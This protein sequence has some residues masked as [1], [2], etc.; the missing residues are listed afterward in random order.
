MRA[1]DFSP[2]ERVFQTR[3]NAPVYKL[4][5]LALVYVFFCPLPTYIGSLFSPLRAPQG[6]S[7]MVE[8]CLTW[9]WEAEVIWPLWSKRSVQLV[10]MVGRETSLNVTS[11]L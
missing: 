4:R 10:V 11:A 2:G 1:P 3:V 8:G 6:L 9:L 5:A 7:A